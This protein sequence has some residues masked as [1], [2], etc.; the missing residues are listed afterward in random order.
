MFRMTR[1]AGIVFMLCGIMQAYAQVELWGPQG[2]SLVS[3]SGNQTGFVAVPTDK[4]TVFTVWGDTRGTHP[5]L[6]WTLLDSDG[7]NINIP[8]GSLPVQSNATS[9][10]LNPSVMWDT[11]SLNPQGAGAVIV[12]QDNGS[13]NYD[14]YAQRISPPHTYEWTTNFVPDT[15]C[16][17]AGNQTHPK[18]LAGPA[19]GY[20]VVW[21]DSA[22]VAGG[23]GSGL[24]IAAQR[25]DVF[26]N[27]MWGYTG[28]SVIAFQGNQTNFSTFADGNGGF[29]VVW[30]DSRSSSPGIYAQRYD[31]SCTPMW[32]PPN[33][34]LVNILPVSDS[35]MVAVSDGNGGAI[36]AWQG[37]QPPATPPDT[38]I[39]AQRIGQGG[40]V[41]WGNQNVTVCN[42]SSAQTVPV[43]MS[44]GN[45][46]A[47][48]VWRDKRNSP[49][50]DIYAQRLDASGNASW[51][52]NG[53]AVS[54]VRVD[55]KS[56]IALG[57]DGRGGMIVTWN[58][59]RAGQGAAN[60]RVYTQRVDPSG[61]VQWASGGI[62][63]GLT[64]AEEA[65]AV[66]VTLTWSSAAGPVTDVCVL[67]EDY[68]TFAGTG[69]DMY[70]QRFGFSPRI[71]PSPASVAFGTVRVGTTTSDTIYARNVG[72]DTL[73]I[74]NNF[75]FLSQ[76]SAA[77]PFKV[78][79]A[80]SFPGKVAPGDSTMVVISFTPQ[81]N[82]SVNDSLRISNT[83]YGAD[84]AFHY[85]VAGAGKYPHMAI[86][87]DTVNFGN[88][89]LGDTARSQVLLVNI[90][91]DTL[92]FS[93][94]SFSG[95]GAPSYSDAGSAYSA[96]KPG[97]T[98]KVTLSFIPRS[99]GTKP[100]GY[101]LNTDDT[102]SP[103]NI[104]LAGTGT[105]PKTTLTK[106]SLNF[107]SVH[108]GGN[109][110]QQILGIVNS[111]TDTLHIDSMGISGDSVHYTTSGLSVP[112]AVAPGDTAL[113]T[114][115]FSPLAVQTY[116]G[117]LVIVTDDSVGRHKV[118]LFGRGS[119]SKL[120]YTPASIDYGNRVVNTH[121]DTT[122][123]V[124]YAGADTAE[125]LSATVL[126]ESDFT[127][128]ST[129]PIS[130]YGTITKH[131]DIRYT[132]DSVHTDSAV[133]VL[134]SK[135][136][137]SLF[138]TTAI[139]VTGNGT[140]ST[141][142]WQS[143]GAPQGLSLAQNYP[144]PVVAGRLGSAATT[145][146]E[147]TADR[148]IPYTEVNLFDMLGRRVMNLYHGAVQAGTYHLQLNTAQLPA[149]VYLYKL[150]SGTGS[151][152]R[153]LNIVR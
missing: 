119:N 148:Y 4:N 27:R 6:Y 90:G 151:L 141:S 7:V 25:L 14:I 109:P 15:V 78:G 131:V 118:S 130:V 30:Q 110:A 95:G 129:F 22:R 39:Y 92:H 121:N 34:V 108:I 105:F 72:D 115:S 79:N 98:L 62:T 63:V 147:F 146:I 97:D 153:E 102:G 18:V 145:V 74:T 10:Q 86:Y 17:E 81:S 138:D 87:P 65:N 101:R 20:Y 127:V 59:T 75:S 53:I 46:G 152:S 33:G 107:G 64:N 82:A 69:I 29:I 26:G 137:G 88:V 43:M 45:G 85:P 57:D 51:A 117:D 142:V 12:W 123:A 66:P 49:L 139:V 40:T 136:G 13:G 55:D 56:A 19:G 32:Q 144:N 71:L 125:I 9:T 42:A 37:V 11:S 1:I 89:R 41:Q 3:N 112:A 104:V 24:D 122:I 124:Q 47:Y 68:R 91:T 94:E 150:Q 100:A 140:N 5:N 58:D 132:P 44:D 21:Q 133:V 60:T 135:Y 99:T 61:N 111:G 38:N 149:G 114:V 70:G 8:L 134:I 67:W 73:S 52:A 143:A 106:G 50:T 80:A 54:S 77:V 83:T 23:G 126:G 116:L 93:G 96:V 128:T 103:H 2:K 48:I 76:G 28:R 35:M 120:A 36:V 113:V 16:V 84:S 31:S